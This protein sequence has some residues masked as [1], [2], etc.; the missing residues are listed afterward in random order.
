MQPIDRSEI[1]PLGEYEKI[2]EHFRARVMDEKRARR[3]HLGPHI[4][5]VFENRDTVM[6]QIQEMLRTERITA[7][8]AI[9]HE[10]TTYNELVPGERQ[11]SMTLFVEIPEREARDRMLV[12][13]AG[14]ED[15]V[16]LEI[17]G[18]PHKF[19]GKREGA[20]PGRTT[21]VHY[22]K[23]DLTDDAVASLKQGAAGVALVVSHPNY[24]ARADLGPMTVR[25]L[26][27]EL[28]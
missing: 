16:A 26:A 18:I 10:I 25:K 11:V 1:L 14:L 9:R 27:E 21:A 22:L 2:R 17:A 24:A 4:T 23:C 8:P 7:E 20:E 3:V 28:E 12:D 19:T 13:L 5:A 6:L 15:A